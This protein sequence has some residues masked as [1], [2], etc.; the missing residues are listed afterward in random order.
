MRFMIRLGVVSFVILAFFAILPV[1]A[2]EH[3]GLLALREAGRTQLSVADESPFHSTANRVVGERLIALPGSGTRLAL[4]SEIDSLG[5]TT[6]WY[7]IGRA[8]GQMN[9]GKSTSY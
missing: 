5:G 3:E 2:E 9:E 7:S 1:V 4:W 6:P 8:G